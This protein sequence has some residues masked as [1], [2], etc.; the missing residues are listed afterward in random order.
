MRGFFIFHQLDGS[1]CLV[2]QL[3]DL[4][5]KLHVKFLLD[6]QKLGISSLLE[7]FL[8]VVEVILS[9][10]MKLYFEGIRL[11][12]DFSGDFRLFF[13]PGGFKE[14]S[15][16][17]DQAVLDRFLADHLDHGLPEAGPNTVNPGFYMRV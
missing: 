2:L 17:G 15:S 16:I 6:I 7:G 14:F 4:V 9:V 1:L 8:F 10:L 13:H 3:L 11:G 12:T 5:S